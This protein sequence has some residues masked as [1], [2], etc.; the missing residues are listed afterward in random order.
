MKWGSEP[1]HSKIH[2]EMSATRSLREQV[3]A[4]EMDETHVVHV[5]L[6]SVQL[7][8]AGCIHLYYESVNDSMGMV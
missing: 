3:M 8:C 4:G 7:L 6:C 2:E 5:H 1:I